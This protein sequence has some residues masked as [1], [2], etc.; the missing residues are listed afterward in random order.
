[1]SQ[2]FQEEKKTSRTFGLTNL[3]VGNRTSVYVI[4][5]MLVVMGVLA[6]KS[7]PNENFP[8]IKLPTI[9]VGTPYPGNSPVD[10]ENLIT[11][12]IE[13]ELKSIT[14]VKDISSTSIQDHSTIIIEFDV[15]IP[16]AEALVDVKDAVDKAKAELPTDLDQDPNV[17][18]LD[19]A[20]Q[21]IMSIN[22]YGEYETDVLKDYGELLQDKIEQLSEISEVNIRGAAD[23]EVKIN[24]D[25]FKMDAVGVNF[26]D[27]EMAIRNENITMS[28]GDLLTDSERRNVRVVGEF[29]NINDVKAIIVKSEKSKPVYLRDIADVEF[30][31]EEITSYARAQ[32]LPVVMLDVKKRSGENII[33]AS[34]KIKEI[35]KVVTP[36]FPKDLTVELINDQSKF[37]RDQ[38]SNLENSIISGV[39]LVVIVL[40]FFLGFRNALFVGIAIPVSMFMSFMILG[41]SGVTLNIMVLFSLVLALGMLVD[42]GIVVVENVF[43]LMSE[44]YPPIKAAREGVGEVAWPI[45]ASTATTLAAFIP[46]MFWP[47]IM[48]EFFKYLPLTLIIVLASSLFV[49]LVINPVLTSALMRVNE[50]ARKSKKQEMWYWILVAIFVTMAILFYVGGVNIAG[51]LCAIL[52]IITL[53][54]RFFLQPASNWFQNKVL[55]FLEKIYK[56]IITFCLR[57][58]VP[59]AIFFGTFILLFVSAGL[60]FGSK[61]TVLF[62]PENQPNFLN[63][64]VEMPIGTD[65]EETNAFTQKIEGRLMKV[66]ETYDESLVESVIAQVGDGTCDP[67]Q[68]PC[69]GASP[70]KARI[71]VYFIESKFRND[72]NTLDVMEEVRKVVTGNPGVVVTVDKEQNGPPVGKPINLEI[73]GE[74]YEKL[75]AL[76]EDIKRYLNDEDVA[77]V[78][79]LKLDLETGKPELI[80]D[81]DREKASKFGVS[82]AQISSQLRTALFG[83]EISKFKDGEDEYPIMLRLKDSYRYDLDA[84]I[85]Q[86]VTTKDY[87]I[88]ISS[89]AD[90]KFTSTYGSIKRKDLNRVLTISSNVDLGYNANEIVERYKKLVEGYEMPDEF[91]YKFTGEQEE[92]A[93]TSAFL[94]KALMIAIFLIFLIL[95]SQFNS[96]GTP[97]IILASVGFSLIGVFLGLSIFSMPFVVIMTGLGVISLAGIVVNNS[98][99]LIDYINLTRDRKRDELKLKEEDRLTTE[100]VKQSIISGGETRLRPVLLTA[101]TTVL[102]LVPLAIGLNIDFASL[103]GQFDPKVFIGGDNVAFWGPLAWA[104]IFGIIFATF[105]TLVVVPVM[106]WLK[107]R[108]KR[109]ITGKEG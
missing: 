38:V 23:R 14:G 80:I 89:L 77:G 51:S 43:R 30:D 36:T 59:I 83:K 50:G 48:G 108:L 52:A 5:F 69:Q 68:G 10:I 6:Y 46:L 66:V 84:L 81:V 47:G 95:V 9:Y 58:Y 1:M 99:V 104:V 106:Y 78:Q 44:G 60:Y 67:S 97:F 39:I 45:I 65:I 28:G 100:Q 15:D 93:E 82:T 90:V 86:K 63:I 73:V 42:N 27:I 41:S 109:A 37:T 17:F 64:Y 87:S 101:I 107:Y 21:P 20:D 35:L 103:L 92:Q 7:M 25:K 72:V 54:N 98:I 12:P 40:L 24:V 56:A 79:E 61:P 49:A 2:D 13:K 18:E 16:V 29:K 32:G 71:T 8:E 22:L 76:T 102:G 34:D 96:I 26:N 57:K 75:I 3:A 105:L 70:N 31:Y 55:P 91:Y 74:D 53:A 88:P 19:F 33:N 62:F 4:L 94:I 85:N 11:R